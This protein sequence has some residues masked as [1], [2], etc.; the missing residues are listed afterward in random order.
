[1]IGAGALVGAL[2]L[3]AVTGCG[4]SDE[5]PQ[6][7]PT[8]E[9]D[10]ERQQI[11]LPLDEFVMS[12]PEARLVQH[13]NAVK[14][15]SCLQER[16]F[17]YPEA[18]RD[19]QSEALTQDRLFGPWSL[20]WV[21]QHG[22]DYPPSAQAQAVLD[23]SDAMPLGYDEA[24]Q[25]CSQTV[26]PLPVLTLH[27][28]VNLAMRGYIETYASAQTTEGWAEATS[29]WKACLRDAGYVI[30]DEPDAWVPDLP[31]GT[32]E[33]IRV[34]IADVRC[35]DQ[36]D[37]VQRLG[38]VLAAEQQDFIDAND[39]ALQELKAQSADVLA[40]ARVESGTDG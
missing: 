13:V 27:D 23:A 12:E 31:A 35:K 1:M 5:A 18:D 33:Q 8:A 14:I 6:D 28:D 40:Q 22:Y 3:V 15:A 17:T 2:A 37:L 26:E 24:S 20:D 39:A 7:A 11:G 34:A 30:G 29:D 4:A 25:N 32:E 9:L 10:V 19:W 21:A 16:G 38:D 36:V